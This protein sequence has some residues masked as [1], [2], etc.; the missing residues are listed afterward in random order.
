MVKPAGALIMSGPNF[1]T[2]S[3]PV[4]N[5]RLHRSCQVYLIY[6]DITCLAV[7]GLIAIHAAHY[8]LI[9]IQDQ[10][11]TRS[12]DTRRGGR[13]SRWRHTVDGCYGPTWT[14]GT[15]HRQL[16]VWSGSTN[17]GSA[18]C[19]VGTWL[20]EG[21]ACTYLIRSL[22]Y[23]YVDR[24]LYHRGWRISFNQRDVD[25]YLRNFDPSPTS[26][27]QWQVAKQQTP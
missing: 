6:Y 18:R 24:V 25:V 11:P 20:M 4:A 5:L 12:T 16:G 23:P 2:E 7:L 8:G 26:N 1:L 15:G 22:A 14:L 19:L 10:H 13:S 21:N 27:Q 9:A 17:G 3:S